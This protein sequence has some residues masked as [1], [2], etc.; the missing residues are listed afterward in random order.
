M[1]YMSYTQLETLINTGL[2][3]V[4]QQGAITAYNYLKNTKG[5]DDAYIQANWGGLMHHY[6]GHGTAGW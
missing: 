2:E 4:T 3:G 1:S 5:L 6:A